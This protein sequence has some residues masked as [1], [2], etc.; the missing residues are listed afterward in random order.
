MNRERERSQRRSSRRR[1]ALKQLLSVLVVLALGCSDPESQ[2]V[3]SHQ[4]RSIGPCG[5]KGQPDCPTQA[6]MKANLRS[7]LLVGNLARVSENLKL[8]ANVAPPGYDSWKT[9]ALAGAEAAANGDVDGT[10]RAC[11]ACHDSDRERFQ[12]ERRREPLF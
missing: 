12:R 10:R 6:W 11:A 1:E 9:H 7:N 4:K 8:L 3:P 5:A 2:T